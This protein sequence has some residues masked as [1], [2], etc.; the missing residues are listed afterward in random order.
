[1]QFKKGDLVNFAFDKDFYPETQTVYFQVDRVL[2]DGAVVLKCVNVQIDIDN[3]VMPE[4]LETYEGPRP[5]KYGM[6][7][8]LKWFR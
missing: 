2:E 1:M 7:V 6:E 8:I 3:P 4:E 5:S